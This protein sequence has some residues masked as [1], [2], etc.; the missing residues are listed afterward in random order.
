MGL[1]TTGICD[2]KFTVASRRQ[3]WPAVVMLGVVADRG[4]RL[5][6][7][8]RSSLGSN[9]GGRGPAANENPAFH[10]GPPKEI[11]AIIS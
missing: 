2:Q 8:A 7:A 4:D 5:A 10:D 11:D 3:R 1:S 6:A 9:D